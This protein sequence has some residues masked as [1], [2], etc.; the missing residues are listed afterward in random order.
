ME[1]LEKVE[2][3]LYKIKLT[4]VQM[5]TSI[6]EEEDGCK[7]KARTS[8]GLIRGLQIDVERGGVIAM[9]RSRARL[10]YPPGH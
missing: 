9:K 5:K 4:A 10:L 1:R 8:T 3:T 7:A 6:V 2:W